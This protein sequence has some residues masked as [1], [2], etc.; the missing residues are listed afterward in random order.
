[1]PTDSHPQEV[2]LW[3]KCHLKKKHEAVSVLPDEYGP[4]FVAWW[5]SI[6]PSWCTLPDGGYAKA[7]PDDENW[8]SLGKGGSA[9]LY[10]V[11]MALSWWIRAL[12]LTGVN[13][14]AWDV[15]DDVYGSY[16]RSVSRTMCQTMENGSEMRRMQ[17]RQTKGSIILVLSI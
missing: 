15:V 17:Q 16:S 10:I 4:R 3:I 8:A 5:R 1:L 2:A 14:T 12:D 11:V 13:S 9:G 7:T 6:Q